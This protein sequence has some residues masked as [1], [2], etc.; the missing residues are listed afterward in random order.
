MPKTTILI[1]VLLVV[2]SLSIGIIIGLTWNNQAPSSNNPSTTS[3][4]GSQTTT[5]PTYTPTP[6]PT[7][8]PT[9]KPANL[10]L[11]CR[12]EMRTVASSQNGRP[13]VC[14]LG[15]I[16]NNG[17]TTAHNVTLHIR[18]WFSNGTESFTADRELMW[19]HGAVAGWVSIGSN[20]TLDLALPSEWY[21]GYTFD[22]SDYAIGTDW[23][24]VAAYSDCT[25]SYQITAS[26]K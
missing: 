8:T 10:V 6:M 24:N 21:Y 17:E 2:A 3:T 11:N 1:A 14:V 9:P 5:Q 26:W 4:V 12:L 15:T 25:S 16:T 23:T 13:F 19:G 22:V 18:S 20:S 7:A